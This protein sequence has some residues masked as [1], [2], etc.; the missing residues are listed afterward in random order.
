MNTWTPTIPE[1][2]VDDVCP[3]CQFDIAPDAA[4]VEV[5]SETGGPVRLYHYECRQEGRLVIGSEKA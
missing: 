4:V 2:A 5:H 1:G 3:L